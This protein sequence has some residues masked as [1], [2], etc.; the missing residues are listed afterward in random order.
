MIEIRCGETR[1]AGHLDEA[2]GV[3]AINAAAI[4]GVQG[5]GN[6][7]G[8]G[9]GETS[10]SLPAAGVLQTAFVWIDFVVD[11]VAE[12]VVADAGAHDEAVIEEADGFLG[13]TGFVGDVGVGA[14]G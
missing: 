13:V 4:V 2:A 14:R 12:F 6:F 9:E 11:P 1:L 7:P 3:Y 8:G 5:D 10:L